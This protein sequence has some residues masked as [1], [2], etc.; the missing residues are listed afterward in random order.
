MITK[1]GI[2]ERILLNGLLAEIRGNYLLL[3]DVRD[4]REKLSFT[5]EEIKKHEII[6]VANGK[7][8]WQSNVEKEFEFSDTLKTKIESILKEMDK[9]ETL[10]LDL[11]SVYEKFV[12]RT[13]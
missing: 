5:P 11:I 4:I 10:S 3:G 12:E 13:E 7:L 6:E 1:L 9:Q 8:S 2:K